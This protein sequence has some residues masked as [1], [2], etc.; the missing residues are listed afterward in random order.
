MAHVWKVSNVTPWIH[1]F[2]AP[3]QCFLTNLQ[4][5]FILFNIMSLTCIIVSD[6][7]AILK[8]QKEV[9]WMVG[10]MALDTHHPLPTLVFNLQPGDRPKPLSLLNTH[11]NRMAIQLEGYT[12]MYT[13]GGGALTA[14]GRYGPDQS[15]EFPSVALV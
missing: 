15:M 14:Q 9:R 2:S 13:G 6:A 10:M 5:H 8:Q 3:K 7:L 1:T 12:R 11:Q 4:T